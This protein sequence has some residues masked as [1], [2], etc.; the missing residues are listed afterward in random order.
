M[1]LRRKL[2]FASEIRR[3]S[4]RVWR[5]KGLSGSRS[6]SDQKIE[7]HLV[8]KSQ[9]IFPENCPRTNFSLLKRGDYVRLT[10]RGV[11]LYNCDIFQ[12]RSVTYHGSVTSL[13]L[14]EKGLVL[15]G[16][17][18]GEIHQLEILTF[19]SSL[20]STCHTGNINFL[21]FPQ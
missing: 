3:I 2:H 16:C 20:L 10:S 11:F 18:S 6:K 8:S 5:W 15:V 12:L 21:Q 9:R 7:A 19:E 14:L 17:A 1:F 13:C 4:D